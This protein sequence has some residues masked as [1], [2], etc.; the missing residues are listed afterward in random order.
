MSRRLLFTFI[1]VIFTQSVLLCQLSHLEIAAV[2]TDPAIDLDYSSGDTIKHQV[3]IDNSSAL[4]NKLLVFIT[5]TSATPGEH[6]SKFCKE[7]AKEGYHAI[8]LVY[9]NNVSISGICGTAAST[10]PLCSEN[11]RMEIIHGTE[12]SSDV[13]VDTANSIV[14]RLIKLL[15]YLNSNYPLQGWDNYV[16]PVS[17]H[18]YW[19][20][21][22]LAGHSQGGGHAA[23]IARDNLV[24]RVLFFNCPSDLNLHIPTPLH[25]PSWFY[26]AHVTPDSCYYA[27]YHQQNGGPE[28]LNVYNLFGLGNYGNTVN[29]DTVPFPYSNSHIL[30]TDSNSF[31]FGAYTNP[32][33]NSNPYNPH[34]DIIV[35]C[36]VP[37]DPLGDS[38]YTIVWK[39][40]LSNTVSN[41]IPNELYENDQI[42]PLLNLYPNPTHGAFNI[43][44][45]PHSSLVR[46]TLYTSSGEFLCHINGADG[47]HIANQANGIYFVQIETTDKVYFKKLV[48]Y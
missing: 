1:T 3:F 27:F 11:A 22:A 48:K 30:Y 23:L 12:L 21:I 13:N 10:N 44:N 29:V 6:Y 19:E 16:E 7:A 47:M 46:M 31:D 9:K 42:E 32:T 20:E 39:Y 37:I 17:G 18:I 38:P 40:M 43:A 45:G 14:N 26:D 33:C 28:R 4:R 25:Q 2:T 15:S 34:S 41:Q 8:G 5:G 35:D 36:E 24:Y